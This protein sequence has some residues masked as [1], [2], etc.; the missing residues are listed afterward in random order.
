MA[1]E[2]EMAC[3]S[4]AGERGRPARVPTQEQPA[5]IGRESGGRPLDLKARKG[6]RMWR[7]TGSHSQKSRRWASALPRPRDRCLEQTRR[8]RGREKYALGGQRG[9]GK[10][11]QK[12]RRQKN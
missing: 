3:A 5:A 10:Q 11:A 6:E 4:H 12:S 7:S 9:E 8:G 2:M 1:G